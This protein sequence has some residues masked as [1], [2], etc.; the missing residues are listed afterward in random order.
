MTYI[1][2]NYISHNNAIYIYIIY[3]TQLYVIFVWHLLVFFRLNVL[4]CLY[5]LGKHL[6]I[7]AF[8]FLKKENHTGLDRHDSK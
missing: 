6:Q 5:S 2:N 3:S 4:V 7:S 8:V 1:L